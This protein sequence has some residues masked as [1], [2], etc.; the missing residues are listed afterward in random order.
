MFHD[1][2]DPQ[3][4]IYACMSVKALYDDYN[5]VNEELESCKT[6]LRSEQDFHEKRREDLKSNLKEIKA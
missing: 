4:D 2:D 6:P 3:D 5:Y 1:E